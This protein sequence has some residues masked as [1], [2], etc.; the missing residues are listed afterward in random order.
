M[1][2]I[3]FWIDLLFQE[4]C[5]VINCRVRLFIAFRFWNNCSSSRGGWSWNLSS[6]F[7]RSHSRFCGY[8]GLLFIFQW[9][10]IFFF[11]LI[12][13]DGLSNCFFNFICFICSLVFSNNTF[14]NCIFL[15][16]CL[17]FLNIFIFI[18]N[19][20]FL[21]IS[22][23]LCALRVFRWF[24]FFIWVC[25][26]VVGLFG[27]FICIFITFRVIIWICLIIIYFVSTLVHAD[28]FLLNN[29]KSVKKL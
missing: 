6:R 12:I 18:L 26:F 5:G 17:F 25:S 3:I 29:K 13:C 19:H 21:S 28:E 16:I 1:D 4:F 2:W 14:R 20:I 24:F 10:F 8:S 22:D 7:T 15:N 11:S 27:S 9:F 23:V